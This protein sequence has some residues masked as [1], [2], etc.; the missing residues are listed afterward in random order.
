MPIYTIHTDANEPHALNAL[1]RM[2]PVP[3]KFSMGAFILGPI[4]LLRHRLFFAFVGWVMFFAA[5]IMAILFVELPAV[6][7]PVTIYGIALLLGLEGHDLRRR[8]LERHGYIVVDV[9]GA[10]TVRN[11]ELRFL[12]RQN[13]NMISRRTPDSIRNDNL[14]P[15][16]SVTDQIG[17]L[18]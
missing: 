11:A 14:L 2:V 15:R 13:F 3:D 10:D 4:W 7:V 1:E 5:T 18:T 12:E 17:G 9:V 8:W 6:M 16:N